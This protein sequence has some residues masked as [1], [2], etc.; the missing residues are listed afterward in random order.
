[1]KARKIVFRIIRVSIS[2]LVVVLILM[3]FVAL[4]KKAYAF[5]YRVFTETSVD[6]EPGKDVVVLVRSDMSK[7]DV[8]QLLEEKGLVSD[9]WLFLVQYA[10]TDFDTI[11]PGTY[12]LNTAMTVHE[13]AEIM[14]GEDEE[15][16]ESDDVITEE[17]A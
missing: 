6:E 3:F 9:Q 7:R 16:T 15:D 8:G 14:S 4:G 5:G 17:G 12:T 10:L 2:V 13:M 11:A 1:M